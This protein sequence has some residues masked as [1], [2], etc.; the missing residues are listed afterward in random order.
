METLGGNTLIRTV[1]QRR[2]IWSQ[3]TA[4]QKRTVG[5]ARLLTL[6][7]GI[8][9]AAC[10][11]AASQTLEALP[12]LGRAFAFVAA[13]AGAVTPLVAQRSGPGP[14]SEWIRLRAMTEALKSESYRYLAGVAPYRG[15]DKDDVLRARF[16]ELE[17]DAADLLPH[18]TG[19]TA[20]DLPLPD[21]RDVDSYA[22]LRAGQQV[23]EYY[24]PQAL[25]MQGNLAKVR[26]L[27]TAFGLCGALLAAVAGVFEIEQAGVWVAVAATIGTA[28]TAHAAGSRFGYQQLE[29]ARTAQQ[30]KALLDGRG[31]SSSL[32]D[33]QEDAFVARCEDIISVQN[34]AWMVKWTTA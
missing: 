1:W 19:L 17:L 24:E 31:D 9:A 33:A 8:L 15:A 25:Q 20:S 22:A 16:A 32:T 34:D 10:G 26:R 6:G 2:T 11:T 14:M 13:L 21:V 3:A 30:L 12:P 7:L 4:K 29:Y 18:T 28:V 27:E 5:H 23:A